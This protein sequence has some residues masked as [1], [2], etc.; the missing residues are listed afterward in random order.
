MKVLRAKDIR[1]AGPRTA[2]APATTPTAF[3]SARELFEARAEQTPEALALVSSEGE[4]T[5]GELNARANRLARY[6]R[7]LCVREGVRVGV[8]FGRSPDSITALLAT[9]KAGGVCVPLD[10]QCAGEQAADAA[11]PAPV[12]LILTRQHLADSFKSL[13]ARIICLDSDREL[14]E[15]ESDSNPTLSTSAFAHDWLAVLLESMDAR[16]GREAGGLLVLGRVAGREVVPFWLWVLTRGGHLVFPPCEEAC[17]ALGWLRARRRAGARVE[18]SLLYFDGKGGATGPDK[19]ELL[20]EGAKFA[21]HHGF[22]AVWTPERHFHEF[23][24]MYPNPSVTSAA[25]ALITERIHLRAGSV[26]APL[27]HALRIA[28]EWAVVDNLSRGRV[29]VSFAAGWHADDFAFSPASY[30]GRKEAMVRAVEEVRRLWRGA[31]VAALNGAGKGVELRTF[32][33]PVQPELPVWVTCSGNPETFVLAGELGANVLTHL[34]GQS[35]EELREKIELY[36]AALARCGHDAESGRVTLMMHTFLGED[37]GAVRETVRRPF[38][39]YLASSIGLIQRQLENPSAGAS[40]VPWRKSAST[41]E[42]AGSSAAVALSESEKEELIAYGFQRYFETAALF[43]TPETCLALVEKLSGAGVDEIACLIDFGVETRAA[44]ESLSYLDEL[45]ERFRSRRERAAS[46]LGSAPDV[47]MLQCDASTLDDISSEPLAKSWAEQLRLLLFAEDEAENGDVRMKNEAGRAFQLHQFFQLPPSLREEVARL[48]RREGVTQFETLL[49]A[50]QVLLRRHTGDE[51]LGVAVGLGRRCSAEDDAS[52]GEHLKTTLAC[53]LTAGD[54]D[55]RSVL[56][57]AGAWASEA[58]D[59]RELSFEQF[60]EERRA[61][62]EFNAS[63]TLRAAFIL[64]E[65]EDSATLERDDGGAQ[66]DIALTMWSD[67]EGLRGLFKYTAGRFEANEVERIQTNFL[68][69][70][71]NITSNPS[72]PISMIPIV[73]EEENLS[74]SRSFNSPF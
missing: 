71:E 24:G 50:F 34:L 48:S 30:A 64:L 5:C 41:K 25:L 53:D 20:I 35:I 26:V 10:P 42:R 27:H 8:C 31:S 7:K 56:Q 60:C 46:P 16:L 54:P 12:S 33:K 3:K 39:D 44:L 13:A 2:H 69:L 57:R 6:L 58:F 59:R 28:E 51:G 38:C 40:G 19:Y 67:V 74:L 61:E 47:S 18:F 32:P 4:L 70:L 17:E 52:G 15:R 11:S 66:Y 29:G 73:S 23:G 72:R 68:T 21:D 65:G 63:S 1:F 45:K 37:V 62:E 49:S 22:D 55:F 43:G 36:R 14:V 9:L